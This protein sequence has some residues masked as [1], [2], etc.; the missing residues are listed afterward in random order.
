[1]IKKSPN[2]IVCI[3]QA[4]M[5][6]SR[7]PGKVLKKINGTPMVGHCLARLK[8]ANSINKIILATTDLDDDL[9]LCRYA[10]SID[11]IFVFRGNA[12]DVLNRYRKCAQEHNADIIVRATADNPL[13]DPKIV[14]EIVNFFLNNKNIDYCSNKIIN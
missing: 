11:D 5:G 4:R 8:L 13:V 12:D 9:E 3:V 2:K 10:Q 14:D 6:S 7:L 1:M